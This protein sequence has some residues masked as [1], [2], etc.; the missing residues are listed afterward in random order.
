M[1]GYLDDIDQWSLI[2]P[3]I[4]CLKRTFICLHKNAVF[5]FIFDKSQKRHF[6]LQDLAYVPFRF[7]IKGLIKFLYIKTVQKLISK[8]KRY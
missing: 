6:G 1:H 3:E 2:Y 7:E 4:L 5:F 8:K